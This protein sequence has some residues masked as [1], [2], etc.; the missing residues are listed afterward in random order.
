[1]VLLL[2]KDKNSFRQA[3]SVYSYIDRIR[4]SNEES[5]I[6]TTMLA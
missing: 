2:M 3:L 5:D 6:E 4:F 1:M